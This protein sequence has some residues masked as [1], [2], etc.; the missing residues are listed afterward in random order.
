MIPI[1]GLMIEI[2]FEDS[3][4]SDYPGWRRCGFPDFYIHRHSS[5]STSFVV[6]VILK[7]FQQGMMAK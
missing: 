1:L 7:K 3:Q 4:E 2:A 6:E 5:T